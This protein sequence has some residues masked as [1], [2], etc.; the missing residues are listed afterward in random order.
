MKSLQKNIDTLS[1]KVGKILVDDKVLNFYH[2]RYKFQG[3]KNKNYL[4]KN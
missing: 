3:P 2:A 4:K 1:A